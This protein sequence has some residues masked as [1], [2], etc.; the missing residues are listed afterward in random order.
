[1]RPPGYAD[2]GAPHGIV[3]QALAFANVSVDDL[4]RMVT[5]DLVPH[6]VLTAATDCCA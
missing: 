2:R 5:T 6:A 1:V 4:E 3:G